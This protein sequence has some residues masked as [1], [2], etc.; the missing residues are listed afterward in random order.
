[1]AV[2]EAVT[3]VEEWVATKI[4]ANPT[5]RDLIPAPPYLGGGVLVYPTIAPF[6]VRDAHVSHDHA[7]WSVAVTKQG[8]PTS[9]TCAWEVSAWAPEW[10][11]QRLRPLVEAIIAS[12][13]GS[14][15]AGTQERF[16]SA[17]GR[18][19]AILCGYASPI[20]GFAAD[21]TQVGGVWQRVTHRFAIELTAA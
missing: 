13:V 19:Y 20:V 14:D 15:M 7:E 11:R 3:V 6:E 17:D 9:W 8:A 21:P 2:V 1:M 16:V 5:V 12:L 4:S 10:D 18:G